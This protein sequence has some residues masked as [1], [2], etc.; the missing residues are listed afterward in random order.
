MEGWGRVRSLG[1]STS[2][3]TRLASAVLVMSLLSLG[4]VAFVG[5]SAG[6][7]L[8]R[9]LY[10]EWI[11]SVREA[12]AADVQAELSSLMVTAS[13]LAASPE[14]VRA[15]VTLSD[16][17]D[18][19]EAEVSEPT[20][21][22]VDE[23]VASYGASYV[24]PL[25]N[26]GL[27]VEVTDV[28]PA[29]T[30]AR[31]LQYH[32]AVDI[33]PFSS[34]EALDDALDGSTWS[35]LH[36]EIHPTYRDIVERLTLEDLYLI[37]PDEGRIVYS[38]RKRPDFG[39]S[40]DSGGFSGSALAGIVRE[41]RQDPT[42]GA[43]ISDLEFYEAAAGRPVGVVAV[44]I[45]AEDRLAGVFALVFDSSA[46]SDLVTRRSE[47]GLDTTT[48]G[49]EVYV[50]GR[51][52]TMRTDPRA[53]L[54]DPATALEAAVAA[55]TMTEGE[56]DRIRAVGTPVLTQRAI[57]STVESA[58]RD[59][60]DLARRRSID[61]SDVVSTS[62]LITVGDLGWIVV[63]E[64]TAET[65]ETRLR[66]FTAVLVVGTAIF[67]VILAFFSVAWANGVIAPVRAISDRLVV[68][69]ELGPIELADDTAVEY[70]QLAEDARATVGRIAALDERVADA[71]EA[72][73]RLMREVLPISVADRIL[74]GQ[75]PAVEEVPDATAVALVLHGL[76]S[77][78]LVDH[79][80]IQD[81]IGGIDEAAL[82]CGIERIKIV[83]DTWFGAC[84]HDRPYMDHLSRS[85]SFVGQAAAG[86]A[87]LAELV[88]G[89]EG[90]SISAGI[91]AGQVFAGVPEGESPIYDVW[92]PPVT[93]AHRLARQAGAGRFLVTDTVR[94]RLPDGVATHPFDGSE[95]SGVWLVTPELDR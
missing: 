15:V 68:G 88:E 1:Y 64:I 80:T 94:D 56:R 32:Y 61:G 4:V 66:D 12:A 54:D 63:S 77:A 75:V 87:E 30:A 71:A 58:Q 79:S 70:R 62:A 13:E 48:D 95:A 28:V 81:L 50:V 41:L 67:V 42:A 57:A 3:G 90:L 9:D 44:P 73:A 46:L 5:L 45:L 19:V 93:R 82:R 84:G 72:R 7:D 22:E 55:G 76:P 18:R 16:A 60:R 49:T 29:D 2:V 78:R 33:G 8:G 36:R 65:A 35:T 43:R 53:F 11:S 6:R 20:P 26:I 52:G 37:E 27:D 83:G 47:S 34:P 51:D 85:I 59:D 39:T 10:E 25:R 91:D 86:V 14:A 17:L 38:V 89:V 69:A 24:D 21:R 23:M 74:H 40:L 92:G 31:T